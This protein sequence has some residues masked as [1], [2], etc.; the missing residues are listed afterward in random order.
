MCKYH[1]YMCFLSAI[2]QNPIY[3]CRGSPWGAHFRVDLQKHIITAP[4]CVFLNTGPG[5]QLKPGCAQRSDSCWTECNNC[6]A[7][8]GVLLRQ[9]NESMSWS[10]TDPALQLWKPTKWEQP[11]LKNALNSSESR[12]PARSRCAPRHRD[13]GTLCPSPATG[14]LSFSLY[15]LLLSIFF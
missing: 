14:N 3:F 5:L 1:K 15:R 8:V 2:F 13:T 12:P 7:A 6:A 10:P 11:A 4:L 9:G